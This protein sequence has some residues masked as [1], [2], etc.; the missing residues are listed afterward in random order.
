MAK[1]LICFIL[2]TLL[3]GCSVNKT[4]NL[5]KYSDVSLDSG[6]DTAITLIGYT[7]DKAEF[8]RYFEIVKTEFKHYNQLFDKYHNYEGVNNIKTINDNAGKQPVVVDPPIIEM[9]VN[10][11]TWSEKT[12]N[13][14]DITMGALLEVWHNYREEGLNANENGEMGKI[15]S[16]TELETAMA[17]TGW[18]N[19]E[20]DETENTVFLNNPCT[21]LDVGGIAKGFATEKIAVEIENRGLK[22]GIVNGGGNVRTIGNKP[23]GDTWNVGLENPDGGFDS[24][25][26]DTLTLNN[27]MSFVTSGDYQRYYLAEDG[28]LYHHII[29][30]KTLYPARN[31][32]AVTIVTKDSG[33]ADILSTSLFTLSYED[34][35]KLINSFNQEHP[36]DLVEAV[37]I[38]DK[39]SQPQNLKGKVSGNYYL[40]PTENLYKNLKLFK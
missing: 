34:G 25:S 12:N 38:F 17:C 16:V 10:A 39:T 30:P 9:L 14:F 20:I 18:E 23:D 32:R 31:F 7:K 8:D 27:S 29:D 2:I 40:V 28:L 36:D 21:S 26:L 6:F 33:L 4:E 5:K 37:W 1:K 15:P 35:L 22:N 13:E 19:V 3:V 11:R 24:V